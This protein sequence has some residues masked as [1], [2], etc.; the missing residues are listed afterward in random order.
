MKTKNNKN[1]IN[2]IKNNPG[3]SFLFFIL[4][5]A[6]FLTFRAYHNDRNKIVEI[7]KQKIEISGKLEQ[8]TDAISDL[9]T[10]ING[11]KANDS[12]R[13]LWQSKLYDNEKDLLDWKKELNDL[14]EETQ[15]EI[16]SLWM[17]QLEYFAAFIGLIVAVV[18][19]K[20][21]DEK[22]KEKIQEEIAKITGKKLEDVKENYDE[23]IRHKELKQKAKILVLNE[24]GTDFPDIFIKV[25]RFF[26][27]SLHKNSA[28]LINLNGLQDYKNHLDK[29][30]E[31]DVVIIEN[32]V[33]DKEWKLPHR[34]PE[35]TMPKLEEYIA[36]TNNRQNTYVLLM[37]ILANNKNSA[38]ENE[39]NIIKEIF[40]D[41]KMKKCSPLDI[42]MLLIKEDLTFLELVFEY[43]IEGDNKPHYVLDKA[44]I[45]KD[46]LLEARL[47]FNKMDKTELKNKLISYLEGQKKRLNN[48]LSQLEHIKQMVYLTNAI[49]S[50][51][52]TA[53]FY[54][55]KGIFPVDFVEPAYQHHVA[56][57]NA[58]SQLYG[59]LLNM[60]KF[61]YVLKE[62]EL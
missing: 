45:N 19:F 62:I 30:Q 43:R 56:F 57:T 39:V 10:E 7:G 3:F 47:D 13:K 2:W 29:M 59:N 16:Q 35:H 22:A 15:A 42:A 34:L 25:M 50:N 26:G 55:G 9:K 33:S 11:V 28:D 6:S 44:L 41:F 61:K 52:K 60:L 51:G 58:P 21:L 14:N 12:L 1:F 27:I 5:I 18:F 48:E 32:Q 38:N 4:A 37:D 20:T 36:K 53:V 46:F 40:P 24:K 17:H 49:C 8:I 31:V 23:Y 54:Y